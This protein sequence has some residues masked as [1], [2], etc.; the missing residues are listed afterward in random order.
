M[1]KSGECSNCT[2]SNT[3]ISEYPCSNCTRALQIDKRDHMNYKTGVPYSYDSKTV[4]NITL[5]Y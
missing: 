3:P 4:P 1:Y 2:D 5:K